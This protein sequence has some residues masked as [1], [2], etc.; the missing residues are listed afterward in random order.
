MRYKVLNSVG[1]TSLHL[2]STFFVSKG[3]P[4]GVTVGYAT[5]YYRQDIPTGL[6]GRRFYYSGLNKW[7]NSTVT[8][9]E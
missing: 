3:H 6:P 2:E 1:V 9:T 7:P 8:P 5:D 4:Y